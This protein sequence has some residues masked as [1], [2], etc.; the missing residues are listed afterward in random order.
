MIIGISLII[1][2][3]SKSAQ[4]GLQP[5]LLD[6]MEGPTPVSALLHSN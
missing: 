6:A 3:W 4:L 2:A 5:W 1:S